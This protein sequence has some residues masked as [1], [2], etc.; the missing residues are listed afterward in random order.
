MFKDDEIMNSIIAD[1][2]E[3]TATSVDKVLTRVFLEK[4]KFY[5]DYYFVCDSNTVS[6][7]LIPVM[8]II[9]A[10]SLYFNAN[11]YFINIGEISDIVKETLAED[12]IIKTIS[13]E[14]LR[15]TKTKKK[16]PACVVCVYDTIK[17]VENNLCDLINSSLDDIF[18]FASRNDA[19][20][21][22]GAL[23]PE[24]PAIPKGIDHLAEREYIY[25][26]ER[27]FDSIS[28]EQE[29]YNNLEKRC[30]L[31][32]TKEN[33]KT[34]LLRFDNVFSPDSQHTPSFDIKQMIL[35]IFK[36]KTVTVEPEDYINNFSLTYVRDAVASLI[37]SLYK[38]KAGHTYNV[39]TYTTN[40]ATMK[41]LVHSK[42]S[43]ILTL[44]CDLTV[45][46]EVEYHS[47]STLKFRKTGYKSFTNQVIGLYHMICYLS[48]T[49]YDATYLTAFYDGKLQ[50]LKDLEIHIL[51][52]IDRVCQKHGIKYFLAGGSLLGAVRNGQSISW[53][54]DLDIGMLREDYDKFRKVFEEEMGDQFTYSSPFNDSNSHYTLDKVRLKGT[55]FSTNYSSK[56]ETEDGIFV[57]ILVYDKTSNN[58]ILQRLQMNYLY[59]ITKALEVRWYNAPRKNFHYRAS[60]L[61]LPFLRLIPYKVYHRLFEFGV[62]FYKNKKDAKYLIDSVGKLLNKGVMPIDGLEDVKYIDFDGIKAPIPVDYTGYLN[63]AYG[64]NYMTLP[65]YGKRAGPHNFARIDMGEYIFENKDISDYRAVNI[66][67]EL[68]EE[69]ID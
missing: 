33:T 56:N 50:R 64:P 41:M 62:S 40:P 37:F 2:I 14:D 61:A 36:N 10:K 30:R 27:G 25:F 63:Y 34:T 22:V 23:L 44:K 28:K 5:K 18:S 8:K 65:V 1:E 57:D 53:D 21:V 32:V 52:E 38:V 67:G 47:L 59:A 13:L 12:D 11:A 45:P 4:Q 16:N 31:A 51:K 66:K 26:A 7:Y 9:A 48:E 19:R 69:E 17:A 35:D 55:Y 42:C 46:S 3:M 60:I 68:Y 49:E 58:K 24:I 6:D 43:D 20:V 39:D 15:N 54:D 29:F